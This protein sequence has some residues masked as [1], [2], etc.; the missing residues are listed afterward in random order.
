[1]CQATIQTARQPMEQLP[2]GQVVTLDL[3]SYDFGGEIGVGS[4]GT[5]T[6]TYA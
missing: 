6:I 4:Y 1:M 5:E 3:I 2:L